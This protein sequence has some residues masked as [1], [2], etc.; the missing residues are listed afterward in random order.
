MGVCVSRW[1]K[2]TPVEADDVLARWRSGQVLRVLSRE[3]R[4]NHSTVRDLI[5][6]FETEYPH[7]RGDAGVAR[8]DLPVGVRAE[9]RR[10]RKELTAHL[11]TKRSTRRP[12]GKRQP[13]GRGARSNILQISQRPAE[14][15]DRAVPGRHWEGRSDV[16]AP[17]QSVSHRGAA[18][19]PLP[20]AGRPT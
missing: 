14:A 13:D 10:L 12:A 16:R 5:Y 3:M 2:L 9:P 7:R 11:R 4:V 15:E 18:I 1:L 19:N 6:R 8:N 17:E 20:D